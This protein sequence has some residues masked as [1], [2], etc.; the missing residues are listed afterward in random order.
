MLR[1][2]ILDVLKVSNCKLCDMG[3]MVKDKGHNNKR[4]QFRYPSPT[5][6]HCFS[7]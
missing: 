5:D 4:V 1:K 3:I 2:Y 7:L 6:R